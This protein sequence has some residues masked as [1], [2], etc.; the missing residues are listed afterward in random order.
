MSHNI[1]NVIFFDWISAGQ[2]ADGL[3]GA[4]VVR[5]P[6]DVNADIYEHDLPEHVI[7]VS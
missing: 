4:I 3:F 7:V 5:D 2:R 1:N 6:T